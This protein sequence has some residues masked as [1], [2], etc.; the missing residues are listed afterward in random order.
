M[1]WNLPCNEYKWVH[2]EGWMISGVWVPFDNQI[3]RAYQ[4]WSN[5]WYLGGEEKE[6]NTKGD[7]L[8]CNFSIMIDPRI[9]ESEPEVQQIDQTY[10]RLWK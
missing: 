6:T 3:P 5:A 8:K 1:L 10:I 4:R 2:K 9:N 7:C